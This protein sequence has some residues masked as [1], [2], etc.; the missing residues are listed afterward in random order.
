MGS[1][2][3]DEYVKKVGAYVKGG[4]GGRSYSGGGGRSGLKFVCPYKERHNPTLYRTYL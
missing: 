1:G 2:K 3:E 4:R